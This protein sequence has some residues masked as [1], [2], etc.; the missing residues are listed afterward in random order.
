[1]AAIPL[2]QAR[3]KARINVGNFLKSKFEHV[4]QK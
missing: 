2:D 3:E 4:M 1:M